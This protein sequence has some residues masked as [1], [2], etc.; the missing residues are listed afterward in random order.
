MNI[1]HHVMKSST[2]LGHKADNT[3][4]L[5]R[6]KN[7]EIYSP[8]TQVAQG[9]TFRSSAQCSSYLDYVAGTSLIYMSFQIQVNQNF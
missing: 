3:H 2:V 9:H 8:V 1:K 6:G 7:T 4:I 5:Q